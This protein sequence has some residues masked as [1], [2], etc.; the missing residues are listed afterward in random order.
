MINKIIP[1]ATNTRNQRAQK[2]NNSDFITNPTQ[3]G[4]V[5]RR[6]LNSPINIIYKNAGMSNGLVNNQRPIVSSAMTASSSKSPSPRPAVVASVKP[7]YSFNDRSDLAHLHVREEPGSVCE[8]LSN[9]LATASDDNDSSSASL[10]ANEYTKGLRQSASQQ[11]GFGKDV[12]VN[13]LKMSSSQQTD[14]RQTNPP[15]KAEFYEAVAPPDLSESSEPGE[16]PPQAPA[17]I[18]TKRSMNLVLGE[19]GD[20]S[21]MN[22]KLQQ[23]I[24]N[25]SNSSSVS[26]SSPMLTQKSN[27]AADNSVTSARNIK[28]KYTISKPPVL[29]QQ[30]TQHNPPPYNTTPRT[31]AYY[32]Q[33]LRQLRH[34]MLNLNVSS[35]QIQITEFFV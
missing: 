3:N 16:A 32:D 17:R 1:L 10:G 20:R 26:P 4:T 12:R 8:F 21:S 25:T 2:I 30:P 33:N 9:R 6:D 5:S 23:T 13:Q 29:D 15:R 19:S 28:P 35:K 34:N 31:S 24:S 11:T 14:L 22:S 27:Y 7:T 18:K